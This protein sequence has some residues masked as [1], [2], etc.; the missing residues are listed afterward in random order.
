M[1]I[2]AFYTERFKNNLMIISFVIAIGLYDNYFLFQRPDLVSAKGLLLHVGLNAY[3]ALIIFVLLSLD[4]FPKL[5]RAKIF[6]LSFIACNTTIL[7]LAIK[8]YP[9]YQSIERISI[10]LLFT[11]GLSLMIFEFITGLKTVKNR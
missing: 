10:T 9:F 2:P 8:S 1:K 6:D 3:T 4:K 5:N 7:I 11:L